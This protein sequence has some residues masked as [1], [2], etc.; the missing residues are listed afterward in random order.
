MKKKF[1]HVL[2]AL[3]ATLTI[4]VGVT[5]VHATNDNNVELMQTRKTV[6]FYKNYASRNVPDSE[7]Y[8]DSAGYCGDVPL[9]DIIPYELPSGTYFQ[10]KY[11]GTVKKCF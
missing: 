10:A 4:S 6:E 7:Y 1:T 9:V 2:F 3:V 5:P 8:E 11:K